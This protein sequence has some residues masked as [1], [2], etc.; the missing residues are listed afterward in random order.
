FRNNSL[1]VEAVRTY[2]SWP[3]G[4]EWYVQRG[5]AVLSVSQRDKT[6]NADGRRSKAS[7]IDLRR[8]SPAIAGQWPSAATPSGNRRAWF[9]RDDFEL[10]SILSRGSCRQSSR[11][12]E[13]QE[14]ECLRGIS[15]AVRLSF[16]LT[17][18]VEKKKSLDFFSARYCAVKA[19]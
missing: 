5:T 17:T 16:P 15:H 10:G 12:G 8:R 14:Q 11:R 2:P 7:R 18:R 4:N 9:H 13:R 1:D 6:V 19:P 3:V